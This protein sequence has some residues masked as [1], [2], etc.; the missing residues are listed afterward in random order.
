M[1]DHDPIAELDDRAHAAST[2]LNRLADDRPVP[3]FDPDAFRTEPSAGGSTRHR[4]IAAA[5]AA[6]L[7][8]GGVVAVA[9]ITVDRPTTD[10][11]KV[12]TVPQSTPAPPPVPLVLDDTVDGFEVNAAREITSDADIDPSLV[13]PLEAYGLPGEQPGLGVTLFPGTDSFESDEPIDIGGRTGY[14]IDEDASTPL[15]VALPMRRRT[16]VVYAAPESALSDRDALARVAEGVTVADG[17]IT[18]EADVLPDGWRHVGTEPNLLG[19]SGYAMFSSL[20]FGELGY[21]TLL[22]GSDEELVM[23]SVVAGD[24]SRRDAVTALFGAV[25]VEVRDRPARSVP[26]LDGGVSGIEFSML[27]WVETPGTLVRVVGLGVEPTQLAAVANSLRP[28]TGEEWVDLLERYPAPVDDP[29]IPDEV[30]EGDAIEFAD[31]TFADGTEWTLSTPLGGVDLELNL[32]VALGEP[33]S[34]GGGGGGYDGPTTQSLSQYTYVEVGRRR[35][36]AGPLER[37]YA[38]RVVLRADDG[39]EADA[40]IVQGQGGKAWI[41][42]TTQLGDRITVVAL[43]AADVELATMQLDFGD[44]SVGLDENGEIPPV[45]TSYR[46]APA[47][48]VG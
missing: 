21:F 2:V 35:F 11:P 37:P 23:V 43:D 25:E 31:G 39:A 7:V 13:V 34:S 10:G 41:A 4:W 8:I 9:S 48:T 28:A 16:L 15:A 19:L 47:T 44:G 6:V 17:E 36:V 12:P 27:T 22:E 14:V 3:A 32:S 18:L 20:G 33:E 42:E 46:E 38:E 40:E 30:E 5:A 24:E 26:S 45:P 1:N 29:A